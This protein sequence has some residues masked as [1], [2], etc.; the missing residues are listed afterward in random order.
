MLECILSCILKEIEVRPIYNVTWYKDN[1]EWA[2]RTLFAT[3]QQNQEEKDCFLVF[4][5]GI[6]LSPVL[7]YP[8]EGI[9]ITK[10]KSILDDVTIPGA[11]VS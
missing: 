3:H 2:L 5:Q 6:K 8:Y 11:G 7:P 1:T 10:R 9:M 4:R